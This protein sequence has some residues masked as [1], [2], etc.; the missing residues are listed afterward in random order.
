ME[1]LSTHQIVGLVEKNIIFS[2]ANAAEKYSQGVLGEA[3]NILKISELKAGDTVFKQ[4]D[5]GDSIILL[6]RGEVAVYV[7]DRNE[8]E[9][10]IATKK[11]TFLVR[12]P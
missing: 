6:L 3:V 8:S 2:G 1:T 12:W 10:H 11:T 7:S 9:I 5:Q 4:G